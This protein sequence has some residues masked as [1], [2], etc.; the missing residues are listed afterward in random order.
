[1]TISSHTI[2]KNGMPYLPMVLDVVAPFMDEMF[3]TISEK[4]NDGSLW[5]VNMLR[6]KYPNKV[7]LLFEDVSSPAELTDERQRQVNLTTTE[8]ILFL[9]DDDLWTPESLEACLKELKDAPAYCVNPYQLQDGEHYDLSWENKKWF[10][11]FFRNDPRLRYIGAWPREM[12]YLGDEILYHKKNPKVIK[13]PHKFFHLALMKPHSFR[14]DDLKEYEYKNGVAR[15]LP[16][17][18]IHWLAEKKIGRVS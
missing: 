5:A 11:K 18:A 16:E 9:D 14:K 13:L 15:K 2:V 6:A 4:S 12:I 10:T 3:I 1:M 8:W 7:R 17:E